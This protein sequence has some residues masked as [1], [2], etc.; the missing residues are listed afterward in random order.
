MTYFKFND[1]I[2]V[3]VKYL[4]ISSKLK[5]SSIFISDGLQNDF[6]NFQLIFNLEKLLQK[7]NDSKW[8]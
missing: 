5:Q 7:L 3:E 4:T 6:R 2:K 8:L 1:N